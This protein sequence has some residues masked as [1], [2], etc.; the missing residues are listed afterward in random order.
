MKIISWNVNGIRAVLKKGFVDFVKTED[1]DI[2][3]VQ[4]T[5]AEKEQVDM[6]LENYPC[7]YW[8][9]ADKKGYSG[10]AI[11]SKLEP[12]SVSFNIGIEEHDKEGRL[13]TL[14]FD[15][16]YLISVY[17]P[18]SQRGLMRLAY[19]QRW[20]FD[21]LN[22]LKKLEERKPVIFSGDLNVAHTEI[23]LANPKS[24]YNKTAGYMREEI[25]GF[26]RLL[27]NG[28]MDSFREFN[29]EP[30]NYTWWSYMFNSR[31]K[32]IGWR[33]DYFLLSE[34]LRDRLKDAFILNEIMGSDHCPVGIILE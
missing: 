2:I 11:F 4:E 3:C 28:F 30:E 17:V 6:V 12:L 33:I 24:N 15:D 19:R 34:S 22:Y 23:D 16:F 29:K 25:D 14:E 8:N 9:S 32:N 27:D 13:I 7:H 21:F 5:K 10:T 1:P 18:N 26:Q 31:E 20:D